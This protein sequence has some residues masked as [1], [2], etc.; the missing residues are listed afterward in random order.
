MSVIKRVDDS[1]DDDKN[2]DK[3]K[4]AKEMTFCQEVAIWMTS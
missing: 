1:R 4:A 2:K 3:D